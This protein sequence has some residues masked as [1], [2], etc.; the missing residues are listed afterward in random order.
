MKCPKCGK[1]MEPGFFVIEPEGYGVS[2]KWYGKEEERSVLGG[3][4]IYKGSMHGRDWIE[5]QRC[6]NCN[7]VT[8]F[9][10]KQKLKPNKFREKPPF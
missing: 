10:P 1:E 3:D 7:A 5:S 2:A 6:Q 8:M 4:Q 9:L